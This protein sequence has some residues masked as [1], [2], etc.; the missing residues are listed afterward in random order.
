MRQFG[1][2]WKVRRIEGDGTLTFVTI[3]RDNQMQRQWNF[4][5]AQISG[6]AK[7][8]RRVGGIRAPTS[9]F[10]LSD[11]KKLSSSGSRKELLATYANIVG[12]CCSED[13]SNG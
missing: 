12:A 7:D 1:L 10:E 5:R 11:I 13:V 9:V 4:P 6:H 2:Y 3:R 8:R